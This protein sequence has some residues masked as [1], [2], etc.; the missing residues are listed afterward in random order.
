MYIMYFYAAYIYGGAYCMYLSVPCIYFVYT[1]ITLH[2]LNIRAILVYTSSQG[3]GESLSL[4][5]RV[6]T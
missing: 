4:Y 3:G 5:K 2:L 6:Q 1:V